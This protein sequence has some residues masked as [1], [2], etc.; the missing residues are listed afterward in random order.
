MRLTPLPALA[1]N[2]IWL[3]V[4][5]TG[6][7]VVVDPGASG[8]VLAAADQGVRPMAVLLTHH[9]PDHVG[10]VADLLRRWPDLPVLAPCDDRITQATQRV[11]DGERVELEGWA[12]DVL[13]VPG[14]TRSHVAF[15]GHGLLFSG[16]TLFSLGCGRLFEGTPEQMLASLDRLAA[17]PGETL[18]C[19]GHEYTLANAAFAQAVEPDNAALRHRAG[20]A[21][22]LR[23]AGEPS[24]PARLSDE[25]DCNPFL[26]ID[27]PTV[28]AA[29]VAHL[30]AE[31]PTDRI[32]VF[33]AL[34]RWKDDFRP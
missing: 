10:G 1:D 31:E 32:A 7:A 19:C 24:V 21:A 3:L 13:A 18:V 8:P 22:R 2:Y 28:R 27:Q 29:V 9:H 20:E 5:E 12:F 34:R 23:G 26:R 33:A 4:D 25:R 11:A 6:G 14:H 17:L 30:G 15:H 16:D